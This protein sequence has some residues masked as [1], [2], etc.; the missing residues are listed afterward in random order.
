MYRGCVCAPIQY[1][2]QGVCRGGGG[3]VSRWPCSYTGIVYRGCVWGEG[4]GGGVS[5]W[6][7]SYTGIVY[8]GC[9][10]GEGG[11]GYLD[12]PAPIQV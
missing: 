7:C 1:S 4:G 8:R 2:V 10:W 6:P 3:G 11:G 9:V 5:R 12:G